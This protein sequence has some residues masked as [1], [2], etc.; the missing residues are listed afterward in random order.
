MNEWHIRRNCKLHAKVKVKVTKEIDGSLKH[1]GFS[2]VGR[3][4]FR[5]NSQDLGVVDRSDPAKAFD[6]EVDGLVDKR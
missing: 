2:T 1:S 6:L 5:G 3:F 4:I